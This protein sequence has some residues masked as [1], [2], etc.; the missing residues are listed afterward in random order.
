MG[1]KVKKKY[2]FL[3]V[4]LGI[5]IVL[6]A[7]IFLIKGGIDDY[8]S[9]TEVGGIRYPA[10]FSNRE[11]I[12]PVVILHYIPQNDRVEFNTKSSLE[13]IAKA[14]QKWDPDVEVTIYEMS[15]FIRSEDPD[16]GKNDYYFIYNYDVLDKYPRYMLSNFMFYYYDRD[17]IVYLI[18]P[19]HLVV[20]EDN[21]PLDHIS[22]GD[23]EEYEMIPE[24]TIEDIYDFYNNSGYYEVSWNG[25]KVMLG[26]H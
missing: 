4:I 25:D 19:S 22:L 13:Q 12:V 21:K 2:Q 23:Q 10:F 6:A 24:A 17:Y 18:T 3:I 7:A 5:A 26:K 14:L 11:I 15:L 9:E 1:S 8:F 20:Y 16:T